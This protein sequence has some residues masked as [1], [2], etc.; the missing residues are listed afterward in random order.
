MFGV[1]SLIIWTLLVITSVKYVT[2]AMRVDND[3]EGGILALMALLA[4]SGSS[5]RRSWRWDC[6]APP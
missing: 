2:V 5:G 3:G 1:L 4:S 6:S